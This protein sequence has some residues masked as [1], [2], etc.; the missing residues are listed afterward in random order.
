MLMDILFDN[1]TVWSYVELTLYVN[2]AVPIGVKHRE[3]IL[4]LLVGDLQLG[5]LLDGLLELLSCE[6]L[7]VEHVVLQ[8]VYVSEEVLEEREA[9]GTASVGPQLV[10]LLIKP[11][12]EAGHHD[13][14]AHAD[15]HEPVLVLLYLVQQ[16]HSED[17]GDDGP[18][19]HN[20]G[21]DL[22]EQTEL[23]DLVP[24]AVQMG[25]DELVGVLDH[26]VEDLGL[27]HNFLQVRRVGVK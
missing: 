15:K 9:V 14:D 10:I 3:Q 16:V 7:L 26:V 24:H 11:G 20:E 6:R 17:P 13:Q 4:C 27:C 21:P 23:D 5:D 19:C 1:L 8:V 18:G 22:D 12:E 25:G 2:E